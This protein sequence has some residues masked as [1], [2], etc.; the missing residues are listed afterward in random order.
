MRLRAAVLCALACACDA[1]RLSMMPV[2]PHPRAPT[3]RM[4]AQALNGHIL[5]ELQKEPAKS[6][7]G[8]MLPTFFD[9]EETEGAFQRQPLKSGT[10]VSLGPGLVGEDGTKI[11]ITGISEGQRV[12]IR[13]GVE[14]VPLDPSDF[15][16]AMYLFPADAVTAVA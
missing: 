15:D 10:V 1:Y 4:A 16:G 2:V 13:G 5:V 11:A 14:G 7:G 9:K 3:A 12:V 8:I 6:A